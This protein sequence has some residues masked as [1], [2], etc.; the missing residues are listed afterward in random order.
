MK[1]LIEHLYTEFIE[2][3]EI[4]QIVTDL[5]SISEAYKNLNSQDF[6]NII[7]ENIN[8][9]KQC[10]RERE[11]EKL[12]DLYKNVNDDDTEAL[13]IQMQLRDKINNRRKIND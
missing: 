13:K 2:K 5:I 11:K 4:Q 9:I 12:R 8:K 1:E 7:K 10:Q 6:E 3:P